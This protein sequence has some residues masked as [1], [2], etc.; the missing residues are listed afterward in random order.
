MNLELIANNPTNKREGPAILML[1]GMWHG[2]WCWEYF[3]DDFAE[4][5][6]QAYAMSLSNHA[7]SPKKKSLNLLSIND[8]LEDLR[9]VVDS[10]EQ[11]HILIGHSMG[12][13]IVQKY[14]EKYPAP[15]AVLVAPVPPY[16]VWAGTFKT[17]A[18]FPL[19]F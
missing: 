1:H 5:G 9:G 12:G 10:L 13:F 4:L 2:A 18:K 17:I 8:Y 19:A 14:L 15:K 7:N 16:G 6:Y 3:L 11:P